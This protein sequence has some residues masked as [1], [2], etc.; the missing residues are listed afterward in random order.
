M[1]IRSKKA[2][3]VARLTKPSVKPN[4]ALS[5]PETTARLRH[6]VNQMLNSGNF[7]G[8]HRVL[9]SG[10]QAGSEP[11]FGVGMGTSTRPVTSTM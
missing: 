9:S 8:V 11:K 10:D 3:R 4:E 2:L 1:G 5:K 7:D 6:K